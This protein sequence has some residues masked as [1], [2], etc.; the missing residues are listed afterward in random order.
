MPSVPIEADWLGLSRGSWKIGK[1]S[2]RNP[3]GHFF[4]LVRELERAAI[5]A[6]RLR[7]RH[8][9]LMRCAPVRSSAIGRRLAQRL[10]NSR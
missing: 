10:G 1:S 9:M 6:L 3:L 5:G 7:H 2:L 4:R 8:S